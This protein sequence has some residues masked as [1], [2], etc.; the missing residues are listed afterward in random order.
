MNDKESY[1]YGLLLADGNIYLSK[2]ARRAVD[3]RG[4][5]SLEVNSKDKDIILKLFQLIPNSYL[6]ERTRDTNFKKGYTTC[7]FSNH[8]KAFRQ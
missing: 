5:V 1:I 6:R 2:D 8:Q 3:N 4:K 7:C